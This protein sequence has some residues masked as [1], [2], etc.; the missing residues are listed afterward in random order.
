MVKRNLEGLNAFVTGASSG[1]GQAIC[2]KL[3]K[4]G[5]NVCAVARRKQVRLG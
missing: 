4:K 5:A 3:A 2:V 1:I